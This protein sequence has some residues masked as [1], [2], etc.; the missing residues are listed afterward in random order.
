MKLYF[1]LVNLLLPVL[2]AAM[3]SIAALALGGKGRDLNWKKKAVLF[4]VITASFSALIYL[5]VSFFPIFIRSIVCVAALS[6]VM[7]AVF[8]KAVWGSLFFSTNFFL[9]FL[10]SD[11]ISGNLLAS[12]W[13]IP[14][15]QLIYLDDPLTG[16][17]FALYSHLFMLLLFAIFILLSYRI[18]QDTPPTYWVIIDAVS[19]IALTLTICVMDASPLLQ[20]VVP[21][22]T[23]ALCAAAFFALY[24]LSLYLFYRACLTWKIQKQYTVVELANHD[25]TLEIQKTQASLAAVRKVQHDYKNHILN[26]ASS[27]HANE[28][29]SA[30]SYCDTLLKNVE[31]VPSVQ[32]CSNAMVN[33]VMNAKYPEMVRNQI[34]CSI[35]IGNIQET[36]IKNVDLVSLL[37]NLIDNAIEASVQLPPKDRMIS[38]RIQPYKQYWMFLVTNRFDGK[39]KYHKGNLVSKKPDA[40]RH[41]FGLRIV[42]EIVQKYNGFFDSTIKGNIFEATAIVLANEQH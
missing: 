34:R 8:K 37:S 11:L 5:C 39:A 17:R 14:L 18:P 25:L 23:I 33:S 16:L 35:Q 30:R 7:S 31:Q 21:A 19:I 41:G 28:I 36:A 4:S 9:F 38:V 26:I 12:I 2:E 6:A 40:Q 20:Q 29:E 13:G 3:M 42:R 10:V 1:D 15:N 27:L 32:Y 22:Y 24:F